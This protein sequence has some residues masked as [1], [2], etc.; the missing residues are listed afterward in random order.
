MKNIIILSLATLLF[1][2]SLGIADHLSNKSNAE[3]LKMHKF[4]LDIM[5]TNFQT[6]II[7]PSSSPILSIP[8]T[9]TNPVI[10]EVINNT[11]L[12]SVMYFDGDSIRTNELDKENLMPTQKMYS[13]SISKSFVGY[14]V[15]Q[16]LC[17]GFFMSL[18]DPIHEYVP[19]IMDTVYE[20]VSLQDM[21]NMSAGDSEFFTGR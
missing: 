21:I 20:G 9:N 1:V 10:R 15:G 5:P 11:D 12:F 16:A 14:L 19:E 18:D 6:Q 17:D 7:P 13:M 2:P 4:R 8:K 3:T